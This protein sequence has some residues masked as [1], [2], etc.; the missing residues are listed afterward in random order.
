MVNF[1]LMARFHGHVDAG[2]LRAALN[3]LKGRHWAFDLRSSRDFQ[4]LN[5]PETGPYL[6]EI[7][8]NCSPEAWKSVAAKELTR[9]FDLNGPQVRFVLIKHPQADDLLII[10]DHNGSDGLSGTL[11]LQDLLKLLNNPNLLLPPL[12]VPPPIWEVLPTSVTQSFSGRIRFVIIKIVLAVLRWNQHRQKSQ[13]MPPSFQVNSAEFSAEKTSSLLE[14]CRKERTS[15]HAAVC[16][17]WLLAFKPLGKKEICRRS[18]SSPVSL[19]KYLEPEMRGCAGMY[20]TTLVTRVDCGAERSFWDIA[21]EIK[22]LMTSAESKPA[23]FTMPLVLQI[24]SG[25][26]SRLPEGEVFQIP[27]PE[28][29][30]DFS[31]TNLGRVGGDYVCSESQESPYTIDALY[32]PIVN[33]FR[34]EKTVGV[35]TFGGRIRFV[36]TT[37]SNTM[38]L[39]QANDLM[40]RAIKLLQD[41]VQFL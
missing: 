37:F 9:P 30:Y 2:V 24:M 26:I 8:T 38:N 4:K 12:P 35:C 6:L 31:I 39:N 11:L 16:A 29:N 40:W 21:R 7:L 32:G 13:C 3:R 28:I 15:V 23:F 18:I 36:F 25:L 10:C 5:V 20:Y 19:R 1:V 14:R 22:Q 27:E 17:A 41:A 34:G 33:A